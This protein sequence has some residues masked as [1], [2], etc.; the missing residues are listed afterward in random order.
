MGYAHRQADCVNT[1]DKR[2]R[3]MEIDVGNRGSVLVRCGICRPR[4][5]IQGE[6]E[7]KSRI[8]RVLDAMRD[9]RVCSVD[10]RDSDLLKTVGWA[11]SAGGTGVL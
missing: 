10:D 5:S 1:T 11:G 3:E 4:E 6:Q 2:E 8:C 7:A 9:V